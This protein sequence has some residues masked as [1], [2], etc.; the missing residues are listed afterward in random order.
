MYHII[1]NYGINATSNIEL[2]H[3]TQILTEKLITYME[4]NCKEFIF[5]DFYEKTFVDNF[6]LLI[7]DENKFKH[8]LN[9]INFNLDEFLTISVYICPHCFTTNL[10]KFIKTH[11][12]KKEI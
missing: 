9:D 6:K 2:Y 7:K 11:Y 3:D 10:I 5:T 12:L 1:I 4:N 8:F